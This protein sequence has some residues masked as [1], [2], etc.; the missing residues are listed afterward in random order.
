[1]PPL[2]PTSALITYTTLFRSLT[3]DDHLSAYDEVA[4][5]IGLLNGFRVP[6]DEL[7]EQD[8]NTTLVL[9]SPNGISGRIATVQEAVRL[10]RHFRS[11]EH[12]SELQ[13]CFDLVC[14]L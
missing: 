7:L 4:E 1:L 2:C 10:A 11:E 12:T 8:E 13:S 6:V 14:R 3:P 9:S 5:D